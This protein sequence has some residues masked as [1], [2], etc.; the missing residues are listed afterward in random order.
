MMVSS[1]FECCPDQGKKLPPVSC[2]ILHVSDDDADHHL[3]VQT[4]KVDAAVFVERLHSGVETLR[5]LRSRATHK[6]PSLIIIPSLLPLLTGIE[7]IREIKS[8]DRLQVIPVI[9]FASALPEG[10]AAKLYEAGAACVV[11]KGGDLDS[12]ERAIRS[13]QKFWLDIAILPPAGE[14]STVRRRRE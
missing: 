4:L 6:L 2:H 8:D 13:F 3:F 14:E 10:E 12:Y 9:V 11:Y 5:V 7:F 1:S